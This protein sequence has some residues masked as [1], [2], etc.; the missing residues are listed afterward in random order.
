MKECCM[1]D[2][3]T[4]KLRKTEKE[5]KETNI[6]EISARAFT[7]CCAF[8]SFVVYQQS[9]RSAGTTPEV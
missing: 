8:L 7:F 6:Y 9:L 2:K 5:T 1:D 4:N 3:S